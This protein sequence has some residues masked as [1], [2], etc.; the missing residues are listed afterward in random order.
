MRFIFRA[1]ASKEIGSG[2]VMR[3]SV[4]AEEAISRGHETI[5]IGV[6]S[7][8]DWV[9]S[10]VVNLGFSSMF[11][12]ER[13][14][15]SNPLTDIL[16]LDSY[17]FP[18]SSAFISEANWKYILNIADAV[19]PKYKSDASLL[20]SLDVQQ[21][22]TL[23]PK[24]LSGPDYI[25]TRAGI[26]K[27]QRIESEHEPLRVMAVGGGSDPYGFVKEIT[28]VISDLGI[29][30][31]LHSFT[32]EEL[33]PSETVKI[34]KHPIGPEFDYWANEVDL[35]LTT[36]STT[37]MEFIAREVPIGV[38]CAVDNQRD[39]Y[40]RLGKLG[41]VS[42]IGVLETSGEWQ[43]NLNEIIDLLSDAGKRARLRDRTKGLIDLK[44][45]SRI[46]DFL[47][48]AAK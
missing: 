6:I 33:L 24:V 23:G 10:R 3:S 4:L 43:F 30:V 16:I 34:C 41:L 32:D 44:G 48:K 22:P 28:K 31:E 13:E 26:T 45:A 38:V 47:E 17:E 8:L 29:A 42:Q 11:R 12:N 18:E 21:N 9:S 5:Y 7:D 14:F 39:Y 27:S 2:H 20:P 46:I 40:E 36:A 1:D 19:T 25:L 37:S 15:V 35:V